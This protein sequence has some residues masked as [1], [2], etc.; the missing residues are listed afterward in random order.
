MGRTTV[1]ELDLV[2]YSDVSRTLEENVGVEVVARFN[3][4]IQGF[5]DAGLRAASAERQQVV[6]AKTGDGAILCFARP[7][8]AHRFA[9]GVHEATRAHNESK[10]VG[11]AQRWFRI[12][13]ATGNL[14]SETREGGTEEIAGI[15]IANAV[16]LEAA[17]RLLERTAPVSFTANSQFPFKETRKEPTERKVDRGNGRD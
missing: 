2:G 10:T 7:E 15:V 4:Q 9:A 14:H 6:K 17:A 5:V 8:Q 1:V 13:I 3:E 11:S 12:G 16:R